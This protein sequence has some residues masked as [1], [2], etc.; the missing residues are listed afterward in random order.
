[1]LA[2]AG[3]HHG[4]TFYQH[5]QFGEAVL[6]G[7]PVQVSAEDGV[8]AVRIGVAAQESIRTGQAIDMNSFIL[9]AS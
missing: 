3:D 4:S 2:A 6:N 1:D 8:K 7:T 9:N 5:V